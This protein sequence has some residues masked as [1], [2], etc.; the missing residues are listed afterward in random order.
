MCDNVVN[1]HSSTV[2]FVAEC[3]KTQNLCGKAFNKCFLVLFYILDQY[4][5]Q[6]MYKKVISELFPIFQK[7]MFLINIRLNECVQRS[8]GWCVCVCV[9]VCVWCNTPPS[10]FLNLVVFLTQCVDKIFW[11]NVVSKR[12]VFYHKKWNAEFYQ[13]PVPQKSNFYRWWWFL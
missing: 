9:C 12:G 3:Y 1:T 8:A 2:K 5:T 7:D 6:E 11:P 4:K 13:Y 10:N